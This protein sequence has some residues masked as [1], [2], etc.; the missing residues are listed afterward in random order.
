MPE[1]V[2]GCQHAECQHLRVLVPSSDIKDI[3]WVYS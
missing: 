1:Y 3:F 2:T